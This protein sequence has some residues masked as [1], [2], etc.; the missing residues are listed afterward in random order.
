MSTPADTGQQQHSSTATYDQAI[1][2]LEGARS[3]LTAIQD[4][5]RTAKQTL[6]VHYQGPDGHA[7][8][9]V[10]QTW[11]DEVNR[12]K[13]TCAAMENQ[14]GISMQSANNV[15]AGAMQAVVDSGGNLTGFGSSIENDTY[16]VMQG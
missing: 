4:Q 8:A 15:Q 11:L 14:L 12:I 2:L 5:V 7:Y 13:S 1:S 6:Q 9:N 3:S 16:N 10:M